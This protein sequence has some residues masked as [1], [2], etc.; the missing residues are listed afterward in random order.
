M[1]IPEAAQLVLEAGGIGKGGE[2]FVL[3]MGEPVKILD[4]AKN[5]IELSGLTL[6]VDIEIEIS[7]L[8]PGEKL[9]E[10]LLYEVKN[11]EKTENKKIFISKLKD[12]NVDTTHYI[13][14]LESLISERKY[15]KIKGILKEF[16]STYKEPEHHKCS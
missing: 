15:D 10:E 7:G 14:C 5:L 1:T 12:E 2:V 8:R 13:K 6:G 3:D 9:Y 16:V 4:L 11:A